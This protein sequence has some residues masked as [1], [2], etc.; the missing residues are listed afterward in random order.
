MQE[1]PILPLLDLFCL[2]EVC[3]DV[4]KNG[5]G[6]LLSREELQALGV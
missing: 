6:I 3:V 4:K 5:M 2:G 1:Y